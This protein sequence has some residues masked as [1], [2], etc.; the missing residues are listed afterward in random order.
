MVNLLRRPVEARLTVTDL[1]NQDFAEVEYAELAWNQAV[2]NRA[3]MSVR[4]ERRSSSVPT[5]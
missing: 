3:D 2:D 1:S 5:T 4:G